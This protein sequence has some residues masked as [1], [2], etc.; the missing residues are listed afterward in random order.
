MKKKLSYRSKRVS[1]NINLTMA[2]LNRPIKTYILKCGDGVFT[3]LVSLHHT[4]MFTYSHYSHASTPLGESEHA[5][6]LSYFRNIYIYLTMIRRRQS[7][8]W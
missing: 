5:Y 8:Y 6:Y 7:E 1:Y 4:T 3:T 2:F